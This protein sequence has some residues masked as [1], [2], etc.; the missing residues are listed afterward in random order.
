[1]GKYFQ[2][3]ALMEVAAPDDCE[4]HVDL[5]SGPNTVVRSKEV[6]QI[7]WIIKM[8]GP[9]ILQKAQQFSRKP[10][11]FPENPTISQFRTSLQILA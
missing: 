10:N 6:Q 3:H 8:T 9:T 7:N 2:E 11:H 5:T 4:P 1:M